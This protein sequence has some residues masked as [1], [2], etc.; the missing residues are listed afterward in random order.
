MLN[1]NGANTILLQLETIGFVLKSKEGPIYR[2][3]LGSPERLRND[4]VFIPTTEQLSLF[5]VF[6]DAKI[7]F[8]FIPRSN[9]SEIKRY[10]E[11]HYSDM[12]FN[13]NKVTGGLGWR[14]QGWEH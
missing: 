12:G 5:E 6:H 11:K 7:L 14:R 2:K 13:Y 3:I 1:S 4:I 8:T 9:Q 10:S